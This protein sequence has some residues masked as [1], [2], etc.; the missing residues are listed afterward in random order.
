M[1]TA[2]HYDDTQHCPE[3]ASLPLPV[4]MEKWVEIS[5]HYLLK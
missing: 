4:W 5:Y 1:H 3:A 2:R